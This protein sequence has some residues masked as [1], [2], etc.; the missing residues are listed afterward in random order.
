MICRFDR[1]RTAHNK[2]CNACS[3]YHPPTH[4]DYI[5]LGNNPGLTSCKDLATIVDNSLAI[6]SAYSAS[7]ILPCRCMS[8]II[9]LCFYHGHAYYC[10][11]ILLQGVY[12]K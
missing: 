11:A 12:K 9:N 5:V 4:F 1:Q 8:G 10:I 7:Y 2:S 3:A 6:I